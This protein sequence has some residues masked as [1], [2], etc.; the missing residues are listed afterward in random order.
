MR[1]AGKI[2]ENL[3]VLAV[4]LIAGLP[5]AL[6]AQST[7]ASTGLFALGDDELV[8]RSRM[9]QREIEAA[10]PL[11]AQADRYIVVHLGE[12]R[13]FLF[14]GDRAIWSAPSGT[15]TGA[16]LDT[17]E[18]NWTFSTPRG[19]MQVRRMEKDPIWEAPD[20]Y[21]A[22]KGLPTPAHNSPSRRIPGVMG[23]GAIYLGD[24][25]AIHGTNSPQLLMDPDP[26][27]RDVSHGCI[28]LTNEAVRELMHMVS[29]G[30][31]VLIF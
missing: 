5:G 15:G 10:G 24:G 7:P 17:S 8:F 2:A 18:H 3:G 12:N 25:I 1:R 16:K 6:G 28:R 30:T 14:E 23:T 11:V 26:R 21:F 13:V 22:E 27:K 29:V 4:L 19:L 31:P 9:M 20:W